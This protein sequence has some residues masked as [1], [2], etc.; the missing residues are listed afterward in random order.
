[1]ACTYIDYIRGLLAKSVHAHTVTA[2]ADERAERELGRR[3][4]RARVDAVSAAS[5]HGV[6]PSPHWS[7]VIRTAWALGLAVAEFPLTPPRSLDVGVRDG[8]AVPEV[9]EQRRRQAL[10]EHICELLCAGNVQNSKLA[11]G[12]LL[13]DKMNVQF[14]MLGSS[15][16]DGIPGHVDGRNVVA[17]RHGCAGNL[18]QEFAEEMT[19]PGALG[20][21][22]GDGAI[23]RFG[24]GPRHR[25]L[26]FRRPRYQ[27]VAEED[28]EP[29]R[30]TSRVRAASPVGIGVRGD[31]RRRSCA[32]LNAE[33][34]GAFDVAEDAFQH[35]LVNIPWG[36]HVKAHLL[37]CI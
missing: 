17:E 3:G 21:G 2:R 34:D 22:I 36:V 18:A 7:L 24:A 28:A 20:H 29:R 19:K 26:S 6:A 30:R 9:E 32:E 11:N 37:Y 27:R 16:M 5:A 10:R 14:Y 12:Y 23:L 31:G 1:M 25:S 8:E 33:L 35:C 13:A 15:V 4:D